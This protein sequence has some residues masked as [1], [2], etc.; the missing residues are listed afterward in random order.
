MPVPYNMKWYDTLYE[1]E[2]IV[3]RIINGPP[4]MNSNLIFETFYVTFPFKCADEQWHISKYT[5][6]NSNGKF[7][8]RYTVLL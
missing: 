3:K 2:K 1:N 5:F 6:T 4:L 8:V 7:L